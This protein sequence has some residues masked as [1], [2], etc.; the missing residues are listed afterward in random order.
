MKGEKYI[1]L[2]DADL[3]DLRMK[4]GGLLS[5][6][7]QVLA[8]AKD[9]C[10]MTFVVGPPFSGRRAVRWQGFAGTF[11]FS[12]VWHWSRLFRERGGCVLTDSRGAEIARET[13]RQPPIG[14]APSV[15]YKRIH[16]AASDRSYGFDVGVVD[17]R[18]ERIPWY[19][20]CLPMNRMWVVAHDEKGLIVL[21]RETIDCN[22]LHIYRL[23]PD[24]EILL[25]FVVFHAAV[26]GV[27]W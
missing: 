5:L 21:G 2:K 23:V 14:K 7:V 3:Q 15:T 10:L 11:G 1:S 18:E 25:A 24:I 27:D 20:A 26:L 22:N 17:P 9:D 13:W 8:G 16:I 4:R 6:S 12:K 19:R